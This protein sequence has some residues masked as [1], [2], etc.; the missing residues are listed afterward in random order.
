M[1]RRFRFVLAVLVSAAF[2]LAGWSTLMPASAHC[3]G[4]DNQMQTGM[5][6][7]MPDMGK[8]DS[9]DGSGPKCMVKTGCAVACVKVPSRTSTAAEP[10]YSAFA[11]AIPA[12]ASF[13]SSNP[14]PEPS[15]PR[16]V[17]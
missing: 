13:R 15:P 17:A 3:M 10:A 14:A 1:L 12:T 4:C 11:F 5:T 9:K 7:D 2:L 6:H 8:M 16:M